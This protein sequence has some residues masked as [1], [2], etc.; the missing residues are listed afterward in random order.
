MCLA[1]PDFAASRE[2]PRQVATPA[3]AQEPAAPATPGSKPFVPLW[4]ARLAASESAAGLIHLTH[5][6]DAVIVSGP[7]RAVAAI[8]AATGDPIW[9]SDVI[10]A[11]PPAAADGLVVLVAN[12]RVQALDAATGAVVWTAA[13]GPTDVGPAIG[14]G[15]VVVA[16]MGSLQEFSAA[17]GHALW[18]HPEFN[19]PVTAPVI[20]GDAVFFASAGQ[21]AGLA[22][23]DFAVRWRTKL[24]AAAGPLTAASGGIFFSSA[25]GTCYG[26][27]QRDGGLMWRYP[28]G[29]PAI[30]QPVVKGD[31]VLFALQS[32]TIW[33][34]DRESGNLRATPALSGRPVAGLRLLGDRV[35]TGFATGRVVVVPVDGGRAEQVVVAAADQSNTVVWALAATGEPPRVYVISSTFAA[36][37]QLTAF[38][39]DAVASGQR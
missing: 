4:S 39:P 28:V 38:G 1:L 20:D 3:P 17:D 6:S 25:D 23:V 10:T 27:R 19:T 35:V 12:E 7:T 31:R 8:S 29:V 21:L 14:A 2:R 33:I 30:A 9:T 37:L 13:V 16:A 15:R 32:N 26:Y 34:V 22:L 24:A 18:H 5:T 11:L 36:G